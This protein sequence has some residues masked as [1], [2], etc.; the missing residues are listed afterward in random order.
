MKLSAEQLEFLN[1]EFKISSYDVLN[2]SNDE[3]Y[4]LREKCFDIEVEEAMEVSESNEPISKRGE[5]AYKIA[6]IIPLM[7]KE[8]K[9]KLQP[10]I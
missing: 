5:H 6:D 2:M 7:I 4:D 3:L 10:A 8:R 1:Q 9:S